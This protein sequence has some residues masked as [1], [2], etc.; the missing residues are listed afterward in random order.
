MARRLQRDTNRPSFARRLIRAREG[1]AAVEFALIALPFFMLLFAILEV[2][3]ILLL[4]AVLETA[5]TDAGRLVRT[6]QVQMQ[7]ITPEVIK[8]RFCA[9]M[10]VFANDCQ[11]RATMDIRVVDSFSD[12]IAPDPTKTNV[13]D[14]SELKIEPGNAGDT[15]LV[16]IWYKHQVVMP[17][18]SQA[19]SRMKSGEVYLTTTMAFRNEPYQ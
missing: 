19:I 10:S 16:R 11:T 15:V 1:S 9:Q 18:L 17:F 6:G 2:G 8:N 5:A 14:P 7:G 3:L 13:F 12:P 4:D